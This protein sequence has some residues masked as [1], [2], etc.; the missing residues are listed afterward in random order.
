[1]GK[2]Q[3]FS[4]EEHKQWGNT[5]TAFRNGHLI[6][7][8]CVLANRY[9]RGSKAYRLATKAMRAL[10]AMRWEMEAQ[11]FRDLKPGVPL[12]PGNMTAP[13]GTD[14]LHVYGGKPSE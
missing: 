12:P 6:E 8:Q 5:L 7:M 4:L 13:D 3:A 11:M 10:D 9:P 1:M 14:M 2:K